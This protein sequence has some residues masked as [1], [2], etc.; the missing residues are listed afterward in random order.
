MEG[1]RFYTPAI[2]SRISA[3]V[4]VVS[5]AEVSRIGFRYWP[6]VVGTG[7]ISL[8]S[9]PFQRYEDVRLRSRLNGL[10]LHDEPVF[11]IGHW[12]S[13]TTYLHSLM[14]CD[15]RFGFVTTL[16]GVF[17]HSFQ[18]NPLFPAI[19][20]RFIPQTRPMDDVRIAPDSPQ[21]EEIGLMAYGLDSLYHLWHFPSRALWFFNQTV[22]LGEPGSPERRRWE[23]AYL[24]LLKRA[25]LFSGR[26]RL[27]LKNPANT[28]RIPT[29]LSLFPGARFI[30]I[31]RDPMEV[32]GSTRKLNRRVVPLFQL[33]DVDLDR[34]NRDAITI[35]ARLMRSYLRDRS[36]IPEGQLAEVP[37]SD[38]VSNPVHTINRVY[39]TLGMG[40][41]AG[42]EPRLARFIRDDAAP[43]PSRYEY[44][45]D[46]R[47]R[48]SDELGFALD[49]WGG[50][51]RDPG[52]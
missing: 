29:L 4:E 20:A 18:T 14:S 21:E 23:I 12:R 51:S 26:T 33:E 24:D 38:L 17:P 47:R 27:L 37:Y 31:H 19:M 15:D 3:W 35:Y 7:L 1:S 25:A 48:L 43:G 6:R 40:G 39:R 28:G 46:E 2:G 16:Q 8:L 49:L 44:T 5:G 9:W 45:A 41:F 32:Y 52:R 10:E 50:G 11:I 30:H 22:E 34:L 42:I 13:G 36:M